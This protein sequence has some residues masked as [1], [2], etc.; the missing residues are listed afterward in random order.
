MQTPKYCNDDYR[1][2]KKVPL[3]VGNLQMVVLQVV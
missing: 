2:P 1:I 3:I